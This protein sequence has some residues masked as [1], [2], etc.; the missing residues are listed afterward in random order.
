[1]KKRK[2]KEESLTFEA[3]RVSGCVSVWKN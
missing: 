2:P 3:Q 1:M